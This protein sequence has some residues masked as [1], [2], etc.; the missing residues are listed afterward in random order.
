[1]RRSVTPVVLQRGGGG[2]YGFDLIRVSDRKGLPI[3]TAL[4]RADGA[5]GPDELDEDHL[6]DV[7]FHPLSSGK[8]G[9]EAGCRV[10]YEG[11]SDVVDET[12]IDLFGAVG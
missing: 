2:A 5:L 10:R 9:R 7:A 6:F 4:I 3:A 12:E 11:H 8:D 1:M